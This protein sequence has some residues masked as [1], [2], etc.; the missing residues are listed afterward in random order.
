MGRIISGLWFRRLWG[1]PRKKPTSGYQNA[2]LGVLAFE[3]ASLMSKLVHLWHSLSDKNIVRLREEITDS[4]GIKKLVSEDDLYFGRLIYSEMIENIKHISKS[5]SRIAKKCRD[6]TLQKFEALFEDLMVLGVDPNSWKLNWKKMERKVKRMERLIAANASLYQEMEALG[7][8]EQTLRRMK[9]NDVDPA[10]VLECQKKVAWKQHE[11]KTLREVSLW[12]KSHDYVVKLLARAIF[13]SFYRVKFAFGIQQ[14]ADI[15]MVKD[16]TAQKTNLVAVQR[17]S[18]SALLQSSIHPSENGLPRLSSGAIGMSTENSTP[19][20]K[21]RKAKNFSS[22]PLGGF[23]TK[24]SLVPKTDIRVGFY[25][26]PM[27]KITRSGPLFSIGKVRRALLR[28][29][30]QS[31]A[32]DQR[33]S[34]PKHILSYSVGPKGGTMGGDTSGVE[35]GNVEKSKD[36]ILADIGGSTVDGKILSFS[37][38]CKTLN[39]PLESLGSTGLALH[40]ANVIIQIEKLVSSPHL[41]SLDA[42]DDLYNMLPASVRTLLRSRLKPYA[43]SM[44]SLAYDAALASEW[45]ETITGI[46]EWLAPLAHNMIRWQTERSYEQHNLASRTNVLLAQTLFFANQDKTEA[47]ITELLVGLNY[48]WRVGRDINTKTMVKSVCSGQLD[49]D[50]DS[51]D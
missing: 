47:V 8:L 26:G 42:R 41:I 45:S 36:S 10:N 2:G 3:V 32:L 35:T 18:L 46:L 9:S 28:G 38:K 1:V 31:S 22:G 40:Y 37:S 7:D 19:F 43:K 17:Q 24:A 21:A 15:G 49:E 27:S 23:S 14:I 39:A 20:L 13:T 48:M 5:V 4:V 50:L 33:K 30:G 11:V 6:P 25:T 34:N 51:K 12:S 16:N 29:H 44:A